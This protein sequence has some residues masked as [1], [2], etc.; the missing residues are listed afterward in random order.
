MVLKTIFIDFV[1]RGGG[2][3]QKYDRHAYMKLM[4]FIH[5]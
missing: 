1:G 3:W 2:G 5:I 4:Y